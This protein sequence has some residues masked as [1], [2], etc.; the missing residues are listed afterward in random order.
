MISLDLAKKYLQITTDHDDGI[1]NILIEQA[2]NRVKQFINRDYADE[3]EE[4]PAA[5][6]GCALRLVS[7]YYDNRSG[8]KSKRT[9]G[10][11]GEEYRSETEILQDISDYRRS[12]WLDS[13]TT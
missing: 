8:S 2:E 12:P 3:D 4:A 11:G 10:L 7:Y 5:V 1:I 9:D 13:E 6:K